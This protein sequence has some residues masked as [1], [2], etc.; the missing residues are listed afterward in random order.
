MADRIVFD[1]IAVATERLANAS[2]VLTGMLGGEFDFEMDLRNYLFGHWCFKARAR[3]E[4]LEPAG[5]DGFL[6]RFLAK[7]GPGVHH[8]TFKVPDLRVACDRAEANGCAIV[9]YN[10]SNPYWQEA[11]LHPKKALGLVVQLAHS[12]HDYR[13]PRQSQPHSGTENPPPAVAILGLRTR[14]RSVERARSQWE[15]VLQGECAEQSREELTYRWPSSPMRVVV[16]IDP[17][18]DEGPVSID[19]ESDRLISLPQAE[20]SLLGSVFVQRRS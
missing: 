19:F 2:P 4:V 5:A 12:D 8:V 11:F 6:H 9:G 15:L 18:L 20:H 17:S 7:H 10:D 3:I 1:H 16:E 14:A 13:P